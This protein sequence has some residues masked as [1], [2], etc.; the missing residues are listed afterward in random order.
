[1]SVTIWNAEKVFGLSGQRPDGALSAQ[2]SWRCAQRLAKGLCLR[3][4]V[5]RESAGKISIFEVD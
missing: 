1:M 4:P 3:F 2:D 5:I